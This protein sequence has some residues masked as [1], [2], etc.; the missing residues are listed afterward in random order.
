[1]SDTIKLILDY[2]LDYGIKILGAILVFIIGRFIAVK[3]TS[4]TKKFMERAKWDVTL[5]KFLGDLMYIF[6][7]I[8]VIIAALGTLGIETTSFVAVLG[9]M[10][11]A[12][13][14]A[15]KDQLSNF[16]AGVLILLFR[17]F[18]V[19]HFIEAGG[20]SGVVEEIGIFSTR[21]RTGD[22]KVIH[23][24]NSSIIGGSITN[25]SAKD[26]RRIDLVVGVSYEDDIKKVKE[27]LIRILSE[28][29]RI[30]KEPEP[31][32]AVSELADSSVNF[33]V[34]PWVNTSDYW[35]TYFDLLEKIKL[36]FDEAGITIP[37]PQMDV[38]LKKEN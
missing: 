21:L 23:L 18:E 26:K 20:S 14:F 13:G 29:K 10:T 33:V 32:V 31:V 6:L 25:F 4:L 17:P 36:R 1:M 8:L 2:S 38:H 37:Y 34:R 30:L 15:L 16:G 9:A 19:N 11:L 7:L 27:E 24:P 12:V 3:I 28:D 22:N 5:A 35:Q